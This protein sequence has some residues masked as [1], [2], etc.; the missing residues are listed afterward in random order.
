MRIVFKDFPLASHRLARGAHEA[1]RC[2]GEA[3]QY[4]RYHDRLFASQPRFDRAQ[5]VGYA[6]DLGIDR[7]AFEKCLDERR[8]A[9]A[10][11][12]D[13]RQGRALGVTGTPAFF[14]NGQPLVGAQPIESFRTVIDGIL[15]GR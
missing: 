10:V 11:E 3:G 14:I 12:D 9:S 2:A 6:V 8:F 5:L 4:W 7:A 13:I 1:A 15:A